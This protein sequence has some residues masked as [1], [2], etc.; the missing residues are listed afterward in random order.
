MCY[1]CFIHS[2]APPEADLIRK[3]YDE[4]TLGYGCLGVLQVEDLSYLAVVTG[5]SQVGRVPGGVVYRITNV[6]LIPLNAVANRNEGMVEV[7]KLLSSGHFYFSV[8]SSSAADGTKF[9]ILSCAQKQSLPEKQFC[10]Y[11]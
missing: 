1:S 7:A 8:S 3:D 9:S 2:L 6:V 10:W 11:S 4:S 5:C